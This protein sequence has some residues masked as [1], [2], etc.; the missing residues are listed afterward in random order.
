MSRKMMTTK[1]IK[2]WKWEIDEW[3][4]NMCKWEYAILYCEK[5]GIEFKILTEKQI[6]K[7]FALR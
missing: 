3:N 6:E 2:N 7:M 4:R 1:Q 5:K